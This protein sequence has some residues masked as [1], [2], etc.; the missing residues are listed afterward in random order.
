MFDRE[1]YS[2]AIRETVIQFLDRIIKLRCHAYISK[3]VYGAQHLAINSYAART[4]QIRRYVLSIVG[5]F[6][7]T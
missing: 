3:F 5:D 7:S 1:K 6:S 2:C 4:L